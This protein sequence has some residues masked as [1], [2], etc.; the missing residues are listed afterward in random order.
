MMQSPRVAVVSA[1]RTPFTKVGTIQK[2]VPAYE[3]GRVALREA[4]ERAGILPGDVQEVIFG[5]IAQPPEST[6]IAR[7]IALRAGIPLPVPAF[8]VNRNCGSALQALFDGLL[9]IRAGV[10]DLLAV[11]GTESMSSIPLLFPGSMKDKMERAMR[12]R[13]PAAR[14]GSYA[15]IRAGDFKP[16]IGLMVGLKDNYCGLGMGDT[17]EILAR[18]FKISR[19]GQDEY[20]L[21]SHRRASEAQKEGRLA[22]EITP[23][24]LPPKYDALA[25]EDEGIR[26]S[27]TMEA[28]GRLKPVFDRRFGTVTAGN[29]S[30]ITD[31]AG[32]LILASEKEVR[33]RGLPV[34]GWVRDMAF[35]GLDPARMGLGPVFATAR[36]LETTGVTLRD[37]G[38][39]EMNEAFAAQVIANEVAFASDRFARDELGRVGAIG[40]IDREKLNVNGGAIALGHPVGATGSRLV[41]TALLELVRRDANL[42][43]VTLCIGGGQGGAVLLERA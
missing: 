36:L 9:R 5:N 34:L 37:I 3:L 19:E 13:T 1:A 18:E 8:T 21:L 33:E 38:V 39:I 40:E 11:G 14:L 15:A 29:S 25:T 28:L 30:Q 24:P 43:L 16:V 41:Q 27:Q 12:A 17:A 23:V 2:R 4:V 31:G 42:A 22:P 32:A 20:A 7:V 6:N 35:A 10:A 26:H